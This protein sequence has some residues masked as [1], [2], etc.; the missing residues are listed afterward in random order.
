MAPSTTYFGTQKPANPQQMLSREVGFTLIELM[1]VVSIIAILLM[2]AIPTYSNYTIRTKIGEALSVANSAKIAVASACQEDL[3][4]D[5]LTSNRAGYSF[6]PSTYVASVVLAGPCTAPT[7][8]VTTQN[9]GAQLD[10]V[11]TITGELVDGS[12]R[13]SWTCVSSGLNI[14]LP[15]TCRS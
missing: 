8:T 13:T 1:I 15:Q 2:L 6:D 7:I 11:L 5:P 10:P 4:I 9:T 12:G 14:H 3:T